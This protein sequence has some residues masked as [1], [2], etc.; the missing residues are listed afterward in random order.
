[1][2]IDGGS[3][4]YDVQPRNDP[5]TIRA[6][7]P[8]VYGVYARLLGA[9]ARVAPHAG[10]GGA[11]WTGRDWER[12]GTGHAGP[13]GRFDR[14]M[15]SGGVGGLPVAVGLIPLG[16]LLPWPWRPAGLRSRAII[17]GAAALVGLSVLSSNA[18]TPARTP[19]LRP[20]PHRQTQPPPTPPVSGPVARGLGTSHLPPPKY[21]QVRTGGGDQTRGARRA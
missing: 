8:S 9:G 20:Q 3:G 5:I 15:L 10:P 4:S 13:R 1:M 21:P 2:S 19:Q 11:G 7:H 12:T 18:G 14:R 6:T 17:E 16:E